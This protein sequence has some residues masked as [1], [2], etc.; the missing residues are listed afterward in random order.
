MTESLNSFLNRRM[1]EISAKE[2][3]LRAELQN[4]SDEKK[5]LGLAAAAAGIKI[6]DVVEVSSPV[7]RHRRVSAEK[8]IIE[9]VVEILSERGRGIAASDLLPLL[10]QR[11]GTEYPRSS[12]SPQLSRLKKRGVLKQEGNLWCLTERAAEEKP[13]DHGTPG[14]SG[15][16]GLFRPG[17]K[18][19]EAGPGG[20]T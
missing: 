17:A 13:V 16:T 9:A 5:Q 1:R 14:G 20:G 15:S 8:T 19:R 6:E 11:L 7:S 10:N 12:L 2:A 4:L 18:G 3:D